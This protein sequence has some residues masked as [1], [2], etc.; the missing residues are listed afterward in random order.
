[1]KFQTGICQYLACLDYI[2]CIV[3]YE[4][5]P[6]KCT[7]QVS[8]EDHNFAMTDVYCLVWTACGDSIIRAFDAKSGSLK[9]QFVGHE[10]AVNCMT[11]TG[12][13]LYTGSSDGTLR[14][15]DAKDVSD[16]MMQDD[17]P[18]PPAPVEDG[19][20][21]TEDVEDTPAEE[22]EAVPE[23]G[24][25]AAEGE[26]AVED[27]EEAPAEGEEEAGEGEEAPAEGEEAP[28]EGEPAE[29]EETA[30][31]VDDIAEMEQELAA[32]G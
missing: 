24:E 17:G 2:I 8:T 16:E 19:T 20:A 25:E 7:G 3:N 4:A 6:R 15:W 5:R 21:A 18:P 23:A 29:E 30:K 13:K 9:R 27:L 11:I 22:S 26:T 28:E 32:T 14:I 10:A 1:M 31:E 12:G